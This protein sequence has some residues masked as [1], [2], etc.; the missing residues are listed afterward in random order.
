MARD[1]TKMALICQRQTCLRSA[2]MTCVVIGLG[3]NRNLDTARPFPLLYARRPHPPGRGLRAL[4]P[5]Q[6]RHAMPVKP[7][8]EGFHTVTPYLTVRGV[9]NVI[10][11]LRQAFNAEVPYE[12]IKRPDGKIMH[13][14]VKVGDSCVMM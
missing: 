10:D 14:Q 1:L 7:I 12:P 8:P 6:R 2:S 3:N 4:S 11:F 9:D 5:Q 13:A